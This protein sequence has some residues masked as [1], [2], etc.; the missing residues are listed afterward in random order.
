MAPRGAKV[1]RRHGVKRIDNIEMAVW[2][3]ASDFVGWAKPAGRANARDRWRAHHLTQQRW[4]AR[5]QECAFAHP[6]RPLLFL[7]FPVICSGKRCCK[8]GISEV[9]PHLTAGKT[10]L[11]GTVPTGCRT[12]RCCFCPCYFPV[13]NRSSARRRLAVAPLA[14]QRR[15]ANAG[16]VET[17]VDGEDLSG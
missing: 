13:F 9:V 14:A 16:G 2:K 5:R 8:N 10:V 7:L 11:F 12:P 6:T 4:W 3:I 1:C 15:Q 17:A